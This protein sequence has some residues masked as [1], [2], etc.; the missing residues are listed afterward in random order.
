MSKLKGKKPEENIQPGH[1][2]GL[3][4]GKPGAGKTWLALNFPNPFYVDT[5]GGARLSHYMKK[6]SD[7]GGVYFG[8]E[9]GSN[10]FEMLL[11]QIKALSTEE[12]S[13]KTLIIDSITK[14]FNSAIGDEQ[15]KLGEKDQYG[16]S[17]KAPIAKM[18]RLVN[19]I[20]K[21][22][23]NVIFIAHETVEWKNG[24]SVG[25]KPD[26][27]DKL[28]YEL[29]L[30]VR[31]EHEKQGIRVG[32]ITKSRLLG[33]PEFS[34]F[35]VQ[36]GK[37]DVGYQEF[38]SRYGR[39]FIE[40]APKPVVLCSP[41]QVAQITHLVSVLKMEDGELEKILNRAGAE[42][43]AE[44]RTEQAEKFIAQLKKKIDGPNKGE[45]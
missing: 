32:T 29:D 1:F 17:K 23:L 39:D 10:D 33:F 5:E 3:F 24:E 34:R 40:A 20:D 42:E 26:C 41:D 28:P 44:L 22:D 16:K 27:W 14:I 4:F 21:I 15:E 25:Y 43:I 6:L 9:E 38:S 7:A 11:D 2:K 30:A 8:P 31:I 45:K 19:L 37:N 35:D 36:N 12:H 18:R 13:Y